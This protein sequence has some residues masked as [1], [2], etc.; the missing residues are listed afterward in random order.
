MTESAPMLS[1]NEPP[2]IC[3]TNPALALALISCLGLFL[4][5]M[6]IRW[7]GTEIRVFAYLQ[8]TVLV[9]CFLGVGMGCFCCWKPIVVVDILKPLIVLTVV[10]AVP[11]IR[12]FTGVGI[13]ESL[14]RFGNLLI[15][16]QTPIASQ[17]QALVIVLV[18]VAATYVLVHLTWSTFVPIGQILGR[19]MSQAK[20]PIRAYS[21]NVAASLLGIWLYVGMSAV[22]TKP[23][24]WMAAALAMLVPFLGRPQRSNR[25]GYA[26]VVGILLLSILGG[27]EPGSLVS[28]WSPYQKLVLSDSPKDQPGKYVILVNSSSY[29]EIID[30]SDAHVSSKP[31]IF[32]PELRGY[33]QYDLPPL[34]HPQPR[35]VLVVGAGSGNDVAAVLRHPGVESVVAVEIDPAIIEMGRK[36]HPEHPY[37]SKKVTIVNDD[38]RS[39]FAR[40]A[41]KFD[42]IIFGLLDSHTA[43]GITNIRLDHYVYTLESLKM[44]RGLLK[45]N[46]II[47]LAFMTDHPFLADRISRT[48][49]EA[50]GA[51]PLGMNVASSGYGRGAAFFV[52]GDQKQ[53]EQ[54]IAANPKLTQW[55]GAW[56]KQWPL[57]APQQTPPTTDDWPY[58]YLKRPA[59][60]PLYWVLAA[61]MLVLYIHGQKKLGGS[62]MP[63]W[64]RSHWHFFF[65]GAAFLLLEVQNISKASVVLGSTWLV[66]AV[67]ISGV[68]GMILLANLATMLWPRFPLAVA[69]A[70]LIGTC[71]GLYFVDIA[72]FAHLPFAQKAVI[73]G[74]LVTMPMFFSGIVF[75]RSFAS[76]AEKDQAMGANLIGSLVGGLLQ[77]VTFLTGI[78]TLLLIVTGLYLL[79][80]F[81]RPNNHSEATTT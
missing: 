26:L 36:F 41:E 53:I 29:Q 5:L 37:D 75:A 31:N 73:V 56:N 6:M 2:E 62:L 19:L 20:H 12:K 4:E 11:W 15:W 55:I 51:K 30:L 1:E 69:Y 50:F 64:S 22:Q 61:M 65:L 28:V 7:I 34:M 27:W 18:G 43:A 3:R 16:G 58:L 17:S 32:A 52:A 14:S 72:A 78:R 35:S 33:S 67:I 66:N 70:G 40:G 13:T 42:L 54:T 59:I 25:D 46:G 71:L 76:A 39:Y 60:Q 23:V 21:I 74:A 48:L 10:L 68:L 81:T 24:A 80:L 8:N 44:A 49:S 47:T 45:E 57:V 77:A 63:K 79:A 38:A 9:V